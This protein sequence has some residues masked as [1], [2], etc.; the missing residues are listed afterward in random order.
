MYF[1]V[2]L[3]QFVET[4]LKHINIPSLRPVPYLPCMVPSYGFFS[5]ACLNFI[6]L[7]LKISTLVILHMGMEEFNNQH[8]EKETRNESDK[9]VP[10]LC[11]CK[12]IV[13]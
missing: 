7:L 5:T 6:P 4:F 10:D 8:R 12:F 9:I 11:F 2:F 13:E 1:K 3:L